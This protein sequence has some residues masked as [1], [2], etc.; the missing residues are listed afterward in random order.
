MNLADWLNY[1][2]NLHPKG[3]A[4]IELGLKASQI[5]SERLQQNKFCPIITVGGT[6]GKGS[7]CTILS[8]ILQNAGFKVGL[9]TSPHLNKFNERIQINNVSIADNDL[10]IAFE[11]V[12]QAQQNPEYINLTY[13]EFTTLVAYEV[14]KQQNVDII[15]LEVGLGGRLDATNIYEN[16]IAI[17][18]TVDIDHT[19]F[20]GNIKEQIGVEKSGIFKANKTAIYGDYNAVKSVISNAEKLPTTLLKIGVD[21]D[22]TNEENSDFF[23][24]K[25]LLSNQEIKYK[26]P[27]NLFGKIQLVNASLAITSIHKLNELKLLKKIISDDNINSGLVNAKLK[28]RFE[29]ISNKENNNL[30]ILDIAH[31][32]Q[33]MQN[34]ANNLISY[35]SKNSTRNIKNIKIILGMLADKD[36][37]NSLKYFLSI[38]QKNNYIILQC[39][40]CNL[41][42][43][44]TEQNNNLQ[45]I[46]IDI[47]Q[48]LNI[49]NVPQIILFD[50]VETALENHKNNKEND[51]IYLIFGS[52]FTVNAALN[53]FDK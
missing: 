2:E 25:N 26:K 10:I 21:F 33:A 52:F 12:Q 1:I 14:F 9:Y 32:S 15:I 46:I 37:Y 36:I 44:R 41:P 35:F 31:N 30:F 20:L 5:V 49:K 40:L 53:F 19:N 17:L 34:F 43:I 47:Y 39:N 28:G 29:I 8:H 51:F 23:I 22:F 7:V 11:K 42:S 50:K 45:K 13:F 48:E 24:Y 3:E 38:L 6:N 16:D 4:G 18:T 27:T